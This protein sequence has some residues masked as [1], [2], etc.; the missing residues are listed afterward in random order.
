MDNQ[1]AVLGMACAFE[2]AGGLSYLL[3]GLLYSHQ[4][5]KNT[6]TWG[7]LSLY[8]SEVLP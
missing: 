7:S 6:N 4:A 8:T 2:S 5:G 3:H 1:T